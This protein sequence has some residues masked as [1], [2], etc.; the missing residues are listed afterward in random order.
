MSRPA[1]RTASVVSS[2]T[3]QMLPVPVDGPVT[4]SSTGSGSRGGAS[5]LVQ[6]PSV[7]VSAEGSAKNVINA[8]RQ[9]T[10]STP[11]QQP[12]SVAA[13]LHSAVLTTVRDV[14]DRYKYCL[15]RG[16]ATGL[17]QNY[18]EGSVLRVCNQATGGAIVASSFGEEMRLALKEL[19]GTLRDTSSFSIEM[20]EV[21]DR[22]VA[23]HGQVFASWKCPSAGVRDATETMLINGETLKIMRHN[24]VMWT[25]N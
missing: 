5:S 21:E 11:L 8:A 22:A 19:T 18:A 10:P 15:Q 20:E 4:N 9:P 23:N 14:W 7:A 24:V 16:D 3:P 6:P 2:A 25:T 12:P 17:L 1:S 13:S